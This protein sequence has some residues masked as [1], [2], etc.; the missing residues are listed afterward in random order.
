M[1][2]GY[3][4]RDSGFEKSWGYD[5]CYKPRRRH[6]RRQYEGCWEYNSHCN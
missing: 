6:H 1:S 4:Y 2:D 3:E 5:D